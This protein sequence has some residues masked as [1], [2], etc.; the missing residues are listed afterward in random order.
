MESDIDYYRRRAEQE[1]E[2]AKNA[3]CSASR[4]RHEEL[5]ALYRARCEPVK[6]N[7]LNLRSPYGAART[8][9]IVHY[10]NLG[11]ERVSDRASSLCLVHSA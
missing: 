5:A 4:F 7:V 8:S 3:A 1:D 10:P 9:V 6:L 2:A 11:K